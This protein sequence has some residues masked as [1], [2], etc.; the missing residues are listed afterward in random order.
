MTTTCDNVTCPEP[1]E[2]CCSV[3]GACYFSQPTS[4]SNN[5][6]VPQGPGSDCNSLTCPAQVLETTKSGPA[7]AEAADRI[8]YTITYA[9][10]GDLTA[11]GVV[12]RDELSF[13]VRFISASDGGDEVSFNTVEWHLGTL[14]PG[15]SGSVTLTVEVDCEAFSPVGNSARLISA[16]GLTFFSNTVLTDI[17]DFSTGPIDVQVASADDNGAP[18]EAGDVITHTITL[19]NPQSVER[20]NIQFFMRPGTGA[21]FQTLIDPGS[22]SMSQFSDTNWEWSGTLAP[23]GSTQIVFTTLLQDCINEDDI[24]LN[25][26]A[27]AVSHRCGPELGRASTPVLPIRR[28]IELG[29]LGA[30]LQPPTVLETALTETETQAVRVGAT[31]DFEMRVRNPQPTTL[32]NASARAFIPFGYTPVGNPPFVP[33]V[34][35]GV[36]WDPVSEIIDWAGSLAPGEEVVITFRTIADT[37]SCQGGISANAGDGISCTMF[38]SMALMNV[39][40]VP[41]PHLVSLN[42][43]GRVV[44]FRPGVDT[45]TNDFICFTDEFMENIG[46]GENGD[47]WVV[48]LPTF[49]IN[50]DTLELQGLPFDIRSRL[51]GFS[52]ADIDVDTRDGT[53]II[54]GSVQNGF[55]NLARV[56]RYDPATDTIT[57]IFDEVSEDIGFVSDVAVEPGGFIAIRSSQGRL[58][59]MDPADPSAYVEQTGTSLT[60]SSA[61]NIEP[62]GDWIVTDD[63]FSGPHGLYEIE[64]PAGTLRTITSDVQ[65]LVPT[66][67]G[68]FS[69]MAP[70]EDGDIYTWYR[71]AG[72]AEIEQNPALSGTELLPDDFFG[73]SSNGL[74]WVTM[75]SCID[76][77][78]DGAF[79]G[80]ACS[81]GTPFD[82]DDSNGSVFPGAPEINDGLDNQCPGEVRA[83]AIDEI[84]GPIT[85]FR[86]GDICW[87]AQSGAS[88]YEVLRSTSP[89]FDASCVS[90]L[91]TATCW[92]D[93]TDPPPTLFFLVRATQ[94][95]T[96]SWGLDSSGQ[97]RNP[98]CP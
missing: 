37:P 27:L 46:Y 51:G 93:T 1:F 84:S 44:S 86:N 14:N 24:A 91:T 72:L 98:S 52:P 88:E 29:I 85:L 74:E 45:A 7:T 36:T 70:G 92:N 16:E 31:V 40:D 21:T 63:N 59:R 83:G 19:T 41:M 17:N 65:S 69:A 53:A 3:N 67:S 66:A 71:F 78:G 89:T 47:L 87:N 6:D 32:P 22:G 33:P 15:D 75:G 79:T 62:D 9:N 5:G 42:D 55:Q 58:F 34:P 10:T 68:P 18:A 13:D 2:A 50:L 39:P 82:C 61:M 38:E 20:R 73:D 76:S 11:T 95:S 81:P 80:G 4:C 12:L 35:T 97:E 26:G 30:T 48:G 90:N 49:R 54:V 96:G 28:A 23:Q 43:F 25:D 64:Q 94:P 77:D 57:V 8:T 56:R 60:R